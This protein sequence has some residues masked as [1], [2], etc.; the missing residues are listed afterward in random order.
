MVKRTCRLLALTSGDESKRQ[1]RETG[2][3][4]RGGHGGHAAVNGE[5]QLVKVDAPTPSQNEC[6]GPQ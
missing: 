2:L 4:D 3:D 5:G 1:V 6:V